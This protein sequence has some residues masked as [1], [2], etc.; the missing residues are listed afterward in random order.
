MNPVCEELRDARR[1]ALA[2]DDAARLCRDPRIVTL[3]QRF[4]LEPPRQRRVT[5][6]EP[7]RCRM[8][9]QDTGL[10]DLDRVSSVPSHAQARAH[11]G[12]AAN[13][14]D[15]RRQRHDLAETR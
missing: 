12:I 14:G 3:D 5:R 9:L 7:I 6:R 2:L 15:Q 8:R 11:G 1:A 13:A 10:H 4:R